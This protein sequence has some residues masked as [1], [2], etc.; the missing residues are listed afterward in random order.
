M[1]ATAAPASAAIGTRID[2]G[3]TVLENG[4]VKASGSY[5]NGSGAYDLICISVQGRN[6]QLISTACRRA[7]VNSQQVFSAPDMPCATARNY[8]HTANGAIEAFKNGRIVT[9]KQGNKIDVLCG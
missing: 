5:S 2:I 9:W 6:L 7:P 8:G 1:A 4:M 3:W